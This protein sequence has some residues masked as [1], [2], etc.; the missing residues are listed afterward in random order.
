MDD[1]WQD[2]DGLIES[3]SKHD[4]IVLGADLNEYVD[5]GNIGTE[6]VMERYGAG[7]KNREKLMMA[8][9]AKRMDLAV[10]NTDFKKNDKHRVTYNSGG[11]SIQVDYVMCRWRDLKEMCDCKVM[12]NECVAKQHRSWYAKCLS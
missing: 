6:K 2:L 9:F 8:D 7:T 11:K 5:K 10:I 4:K 12:V 1:F 3:V